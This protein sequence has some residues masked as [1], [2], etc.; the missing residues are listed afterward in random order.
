[1]NFSLSWSMDNAL[2]EVI[3]WLTEIKQTSYNALQNKTIYSFK[4][5]L[6][7]KK[8][9]IAPIRLPEPSTIE[10]IWKKLPK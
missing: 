3:F 7:A 1:M 8:L 10:D 5:F 4:Y 2:G 9:D 6:T